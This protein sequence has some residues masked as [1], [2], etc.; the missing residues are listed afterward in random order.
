M[1][2]AIVAF[3]LGST[4]VKKSGI[5]GPTMS[6]WRMILTSCLWLAIL[7]LTEHRWITWAEIR[8]A[9]IPGVVFGL[10]ITAFFTGV[11]KTTVANAEFIGALTPII[12]VPAGALLFK[13]K[14]NGRALWFGVVSLVGLMLVLFNV[15]SNSVATWEGNLLIVFAMF[16]WATYLLTSR[17]LR[18]QMSVQSILCAVMI[19]GSVTVLP[20]AVFTGNVDEVTTRS[21]PYIVLLAIMTGAGA[22]GLIVY[23]QQS[24]PV[25]TISIM[26]V[27]QPALAVIWAYL[28]LDQT[29]RPIQLLGML[30]VLVGL[31]M[32]V[33]LSRRTAPQSAPPGDEPLGP[34]A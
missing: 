12:L 34:E 31:A 10:N 18:Q 25:G 19:V 21:I 27:A 9:A 26:Q 33:T 1:L 13:E 16:S 23:A 32:V 29:I 22:H 17:R 30:L 24:V 4:I 5:P 20:L 15:P 3:S 11:T 8:L 6:F 28:L 2:G 7:R 14:V